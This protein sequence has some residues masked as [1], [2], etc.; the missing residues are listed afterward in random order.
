MTRTKDF[1]EFLQATVAKDHQLAKGVRR[2][3]FNAD[4]ACQIYNLR[5][6]AGM[7]QRQLADRV[8]TTQSVISRIEDDDYDGHSL[9]LLWRIAEALSKELRIQ[10]VAPVIPYQPTITEE[11]SVDWGTFGS[12]EPQFRYGGNALSN[13]NPLILTANALTVLTCVRSDYPALETLRS[14]SK[15]AVAQNG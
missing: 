10:F 12:W 15:N 3:L 1:A 13:A 5:T 6:E 7:T 4:I 14:G 9:D 8:K 11:F 2:E